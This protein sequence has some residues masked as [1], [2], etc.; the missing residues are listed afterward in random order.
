MTKTTGY[1]AIHTETKLTI[2]GVGDT[3]EAA[4]TDALSNG[5]LFDA[6]GEELTEAE[7]RAK[8]ETYP[9]TPALLAKIDAEGGAIGWDERDGIADVD[10]DDRWAA[11]QAELSTAEIESLAMEMTNAEH[12]ELDAEGDVWISKP[13][14]GH[15]LDSDKIAELVRFIEGRRE[16]EGTA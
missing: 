5:A 11:I 15:W 4:I 2:D 8:F 6:E 13:M 9:A 3:A 1:V 10:L 16:A 14:V 12:A 7:A